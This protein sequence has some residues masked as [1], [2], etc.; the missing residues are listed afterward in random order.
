VRANDPY[1]EKTVRTME[2]FGIDTLFSVGANRGQY[3]LQLRRTGYRHR[4]ISFE[5]L[6]SAFR[7]LE[8]NAANDPLWTVNNFALGDEDRISVIN[9]AG[10]SYSSSLLDMLPAHYESAPNSKYIGQEMTEV[11][12]LDTVFSQFAQQ[13]DTIM[14]KIDTQGFEKNVLE[15][16]A[17]SLEYIRVVQLEIS[18]VPLYRDE[19]LLVDMLRYMNEKGYLLYLMTEEF[20]DENTCQLLQVNTTFVKKD[21][22]VNSR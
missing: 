13:G 12:K 20:S 8:Q 16:A 9:V 15:G 22:M 21:F 5:P 7:V 3:A 4:I 2:R 1:I 14:L 10:N 18:I 17:A 11:R 19:M 6:K